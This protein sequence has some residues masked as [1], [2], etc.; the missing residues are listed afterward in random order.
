MPKASIIIRT[1][2]EER[3][4]RSCLEASA[5][6]DH[7]IRVVED[8][9]LIGVVDRARILASIADTIAS[10]TTAAPRPYRRQ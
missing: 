2:N 1:R 7:P 4:I 9:R 3:W 8:G 10:S 5:A 6:S